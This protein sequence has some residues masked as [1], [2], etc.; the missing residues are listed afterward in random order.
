MQG[1]SGVATGAGVATTAGAGIAG[2]VRAGSGGGVGR[3]ASES[4]VAR[5]PRVI[6]PPG[7]LP[8][9]GGRRTGGRSPSGGGPGSGVG[10]GSGVGPMT[11]IALMG[12]ALR[13]S[14]AEASVAPEP[15]GALGERTGVGVGAGVGSEAGRTAVALPAEGPAAPT[16]RGAHSTQ[17]QRSRTGRRGESGRGRRPSFMIECWPANGNSLSLG[18]LSRSCKRCRRTIRILSPHCG[19]RQEESRVGA[20]M[21]GPRSRSPAW[22]GTGDR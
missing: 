14:G 16:G 19:R 12:W 6:A 4:E 18:T 17:T 7:P 5:S 2:G 9:D 10:V 22:R 1:A 21:A 3:G 13:L 8:G 20:A 15:V 11:K